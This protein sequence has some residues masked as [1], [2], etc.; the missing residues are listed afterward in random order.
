MDVNVGVGVSGARE[1]AEQIAALNR[2]IAKLWSEGLNTRQ[3]VENAKKLSQGLH[4]VGRE[5]RDII[6]PS[7]SSLGVTLGAGAFAASMIGI[8]KAARD[9]ARATIEMGYIAK[10]TGISIETMKGYAAAAQSHGISNDEAMASIT[11]FGR[12]ADDIRN[13]MSELRGTLVGWGEGALVRAIQNS[14][15][16]AEALAATLKRMDELR[17]RAPDRA[18]M[19]AEQLLGDYRFINLSLA[20]VAKWAAEAVAPSKEAEEAAR[21]FNQTMRELDEA[22]DDVKQ[23]LGAAVLPGFTKAMENLTKIYNDNP[24]AFQPIVQGFED[25]AKAIQR[26]TSRDLTAAGRAF[27]GAVN[28]ALKS[29]SAIYRM[30]E[31]VASQHAT[32]EE[33]KAPPPVPYKPWT[34]R[35]PSLGSVI[36][37]MTGANADTQAQ[38]Q[39]EPFKDLSKHLDRTADLLREINIRNDLI[40]R[41]VIGGS[42][43]AAGGGVAF[44]GGYSVGA[45]GPAANIPGFAPATPTGG[46]QAVGPATGAIGAGFVPG[47]GYGPG[48]GGPRAAGGDPSVVGQKRGGGGN[49]DAGALYKSYVAKFKGGPLDGYVPPDGPKWGITKGTPEEWAALALATSQQESGL[50]RYAGNG[51]LN[52]FNSGDLARYGLAGR[53]VD[54]PDAQA[55]ALVNQWHQSIPQD[56]IIAGTNAAGRWGG[57]TRYFGSMRRRGEADKYLGWAHSI[58]TEVDAKGAPSPT[59]APSSSAVLDWQGAMQAAKDNPQASSGG[60][61]TGFA[62]P[63]QPII[64]DRTRGLPSYMLD[65]AIRDENAPTSN[66]LHINVRVKAP[67]GTVDVKT[68]AAG[69]DIASVMQRRERTKS[70]QQPEPRKAIEPEKAAAHG[71]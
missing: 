49:V 65:N 6:T 5:L 37:G 45:G 9:F 34:W 2:D 25:A 51:G 20:D 67:Q 69:D 54:D 11:A 55:Q 48:G 53:R 22:L 33:M 35:L 7:L 50:N 16:N 57:A 26:I 41:G 17:E 52:Q 63:E 30:L 12:K 42:G 43:A 40:R 18:R 10:E 31:W 71:E 24:E 32:A 66:K 28:I 14:R 3:P 29:A 46:P 58:A 36:G 68:N 21:K 1:S 8:T 60:S 23:D 15:T 38:Q 13:N 64:P 70:E 62:K 44:P 61:A 27:G 56:Q 19:L 4:A 59:K 47:S 39:A